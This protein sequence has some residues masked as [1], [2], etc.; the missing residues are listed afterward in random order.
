MSLILLFGHMIVTLVF[1]F[2]CFCELDYDFHTLFWKLNF[3]FH[4]FKQLSWNCKALQQKD[5]VPH[6]KQ[7]MSKHQLQP[8]SKAVIRRTTLHE[9]ALAGYNSDRGS[10]CAQIPRILMELWL[11]PEKRRVWIQISERQNVFNV[12]LFA[13]RF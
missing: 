8:P 13:S 5:V 3:V 6:I 9:N 1:V 12:S 2:L 10:L 7:H 11:H 4:I